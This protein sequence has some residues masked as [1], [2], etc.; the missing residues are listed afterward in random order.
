MKGEVRFPKRGPTR[1]SEHLSRS[2]GVSCEELP[3]LGDI[4]DTTRPSS[5]LWA[6]REVVDFVVIRCDGGSRTKFIGKPRQPARVT[7][8][9]PVGSASGFYR[10]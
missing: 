9:R 8:T 2:S 6:V 1:V 7:F 10:Q 4:A 3:D 5:C